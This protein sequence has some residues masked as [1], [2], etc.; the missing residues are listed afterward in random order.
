[1]TGFLVFALP[2]FALFAF[3]AGE[4]ALGLTLLGAAAVCLLLIGRAS[5]RR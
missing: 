2:V 4:W 5:A 3:I 1:V